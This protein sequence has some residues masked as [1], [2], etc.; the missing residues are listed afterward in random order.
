[1]KPQLLL[2][3]PHQ[4]WHNDVLTCVFPVLLLFLLAVTPEA[5]LAPLPRHH[6]QPRRSRSVGRIRT[7]TTRRTAAPAGVTAESVGLRDLYPAS[8]TW[9][10]GTLPVDDLHTLHYE[11]HRGSNSTDADKNERRPRLNAL[12][13]HGG[14]GAGCNPRHARFFDTSQYTVVLLDQR[15]SGRSTP[16]GATRQ[17]TLLD[18]VKD[19]E[20]L[21]RHLQLQRWDVVLGGSW[22]ATLALAY[23]A[24]YPAAVRSLILRGVCLM[25]PCEIDWLFAGGAA[26]LYPQAWRDFCQAVVPEGGSS[27]SSTTSNTRCDPRDALHAYYDRLLGDDPTM[28][29]AAAR[30]WMQWEMTVYASTNATCAQADFYAKAYAPVAVFDGTSWSYRDGEDRPIAED[31]IQKLGL[32][33]DCAV[34]VERLRAGLAAPDTPLVSEQPATMRPVQPMAVVEEDSTTTTESTPPPEY[35]SFVPAQNMLTCFYSVN[36]RYALNDL[37]LLDLLPRHIPCI[38]V[39]GGM[40]R[41]CPPDT[42]LDVAR[43]WSTNSS[44]NCGLELRIPLKSGHSMYDPAIANELVRATNRMAMRLLKCDGGV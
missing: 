12:F 39:Q 20:R 28:R 6:Y 29:M 31:I 22:G 23:A 34:A 15:G 7:S 27:S 5:L 11:I 18:L 35:A 14:P 4:S 38:A 2:L 25:R 17:N 36:H 16:R 21:R 32:P 26:R 43:E 10:N 1:M 30:S 37:S 40:D 41:V 44:G 8:A 24:R 33:S 13:L 3:L 42:A 9:T 19:C